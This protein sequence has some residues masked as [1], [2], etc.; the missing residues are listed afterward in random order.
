M[1]TLVLPTPDWAHAAVT[2]LRPETPDHLIERPQ[3]LLDHFL[4]GG[5]IFLRD[6]GHGGQPGTVAKMRALY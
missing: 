6:K 4:C 2:I 5:L 1:T 3:G